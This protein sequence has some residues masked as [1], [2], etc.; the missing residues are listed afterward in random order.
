MAASVPATGLL[1]H[2][3]ARAMRG[4]TTPEERVSILAPVMRPLTPHWTLHF[5]SPVPADISTVGDEALVRFAD[6]TLK[7]LI[8]Q[9]F[10]PSAGA[11]PPSTQQ[12]GSHP[13]LGWASG[14]WKR[15]VRRLTSR[16]ARPAGHGF[17]SQFRRLG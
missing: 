17:H 4:S 11:A 15:G 2:S 14:Y 13:W 9:P 7:F 6:A 12:W 5:H 3:L 16:R 8:G 10:P 1:I